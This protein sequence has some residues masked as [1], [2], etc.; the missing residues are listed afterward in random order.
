MSNVI[1]PLPLPLSSPLPLS[2]LPLF[3][4]AVS[5]KAERGQGRGGKQLCVTSLW[6]QICARI[7][8][9]LAVLE[10]VL[11]ERVLSLTPVP[12]PLPLSSSRPP[13]LVLLFPSAVSAKAERG[14]DRGGKQL[15]AITLA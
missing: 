2:V 1:V 5:A 8:S 6:A 7:S 14:Q 15:Y 3:L 11:L 4:T 13:L 10:I 9:L 12:L